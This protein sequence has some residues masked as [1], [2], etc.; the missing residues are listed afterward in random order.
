MDWNNANAGYVIAAYA[1]SAGCLMSLVVWCLIR[2]NAATN[3]L[4]KGKTNP[5]A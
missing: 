3:A 5:F 4:K 1:I 2:H